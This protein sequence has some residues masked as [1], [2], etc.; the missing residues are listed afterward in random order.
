MPPQSSPR[1]DRAVRLVT[2]GKFDAKGAVVRKQHNNDA[3]HMRLH[4]ETRTHTRPYM[5]TSDSYKQIDSDDKDA[6]EKAISALAACGDS[7]DDD[8]GA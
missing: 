2:S 3:P 1:K 5:H 8:D 6:I 4:T 7:D